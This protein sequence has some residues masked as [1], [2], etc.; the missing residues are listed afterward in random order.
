MEKKTLVYSTLKLIAIF[1]LLG[2]LTLLYLNS[3]LHKKPFLTQPK[4]FPE[5][6]TQPQTPKVSPNFKWTV[7]N[8][9]YQLSDFRGKIVYFNFWASWCPPCAKE[10]PVLQEI[11][12]RFQK[13]SLAVVLI[14][15]DSEEDFSKAQKLLDQDHIEL[16]NSYDPQSFRAQLS[17]QALPEH[18]IV[19][20]QGKVM[21]E[22]FGDILTRKESVIEYL[23]VL[24]AKTQQ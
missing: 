4:P 22:F 11:Q 9:L 14:N 1:A 12:N 17:I 5:L 10:L 7:K 24:G 15:L 3:S 21:G 13:D 8:Q 18:F 2:L 23:K 19:D 20:A 16:L 6:L